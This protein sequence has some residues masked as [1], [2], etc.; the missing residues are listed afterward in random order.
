MSRARISS[1][2]TSLGPGRLKYFEPSTANTRAL[3]TAGMACHS[4]RSLRGSHPSASGFRRSRTAS[5][6]SPPAPLASGLPWT[7]GPRA[8]VLPQARPSRPP[9][10]PSP[11]PN[12]PR[13]TRDPAIRDRPPSAWGGPRHAAR[14]AFQPFPQG[15][16]QGLRP[17]RCPGC[18]PTRVMSRNTSPREPGDSDSILAGGFSEPAAAMTSS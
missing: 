16:D 7:P 18:V 8:R 6:P 15:V 14:H 10:R 1:P 17:L 3:A 9:T 5:A 13:R 11:A 2:S 4:G 12:G